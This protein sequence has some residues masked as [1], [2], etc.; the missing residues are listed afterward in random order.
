MKG[1]GIVAM[2]RE[3]KAPVALLREDF[4]LLADLAEE[5]LSSLRSL[6]ESECAWECLPGGVFARD[7]WWNTEWLVDDAG[8]LYKLADE[9][10][11]TITRAITI[12]DAAGE[13]VRKEGSP[14]MVRFVEGT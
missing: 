12:L 1:R 3:S 11:A 13:I 9:E 4:A 8:D 5:G 10:R 2:L 14:N 7:G 6:I